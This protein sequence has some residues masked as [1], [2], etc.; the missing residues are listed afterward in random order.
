[1][2]ACQ[3]GW[4]NTMNST[5][6]I[7]MFWRHIFTRNNRLSDSGELY[8]WGRNDTACLGLGHLNN[9]YFP[10]KVG[11]KSQSQAKFSQ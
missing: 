9:Q 4:P 6:Y 1:M 5:L 2:A 3:L 10:F 7:F 8:M 11:R